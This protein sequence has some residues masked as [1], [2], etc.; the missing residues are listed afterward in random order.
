MDI[1]T[2]TVEYIMT[3][4]AVLAERVDE[5]VSG[6]IPQEAAGLEALSDRLEHAGEGIKL[7]AHACALIRNM[8]D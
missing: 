5:D 7:L 3:R 4:I 8:R 6:I 1:E 2:Q